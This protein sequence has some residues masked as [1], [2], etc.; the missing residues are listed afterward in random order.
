MINGSVRHGLRGTE[1]HLRELVLD[2]ALL[3]TLR[4]VALSTCTVRRVLLT[5]LTGL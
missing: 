5:Y 2:L 4:K 1:S 3:S